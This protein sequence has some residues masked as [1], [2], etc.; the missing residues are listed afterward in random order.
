MSDRIAVMQQG[1]IVELNDAEG[2]YN[3]PQS[4][5]TKKL[6]EAIPRVI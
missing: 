4:A 1:Q 6:I 3:N 5:F 2:I